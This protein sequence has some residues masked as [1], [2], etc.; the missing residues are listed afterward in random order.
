MKSNHRLIK[1]T[2]AAMLAG[3]TFATLAQNKNTQNQPRREAEGAQGIV[4]DAQP[5]PPEKPKAEEPQAQKRHKKHKQP[6]HFT[7]KVPKET[8]AKKP[9]VKKTEKA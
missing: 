4:I 7:A 9:K 3:L 1:I 2:L 8:P 5:L 6:E